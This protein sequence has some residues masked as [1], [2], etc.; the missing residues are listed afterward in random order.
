LQKGEH[1]EEKGIWIMSLALAL[2]FALSFGAAAEEGVTDTSI[3]IGQWGPQTGPA[4]PWGAVARGT[5]VYF[6]MINDEGGINGRKIEYRMFDDAYNPAKTKAGVK[7]LQEGKGYSDGLQASAPPAAWPSKT[8]SW[9]RRSLGRT[10]SRV[11]SLDLAA[12]EISL[13]RVS[14]LLFGG[15]D[16]DQVCGRKDYG[17]KKVAIA[18]QNDDYGKNGVAGAEK[19]LA[20]STG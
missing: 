10:G 4:A 7:E 16:S 6:Q 14:S 13:C 15:P 5:G 12:P 9:K 1:Y 2:L 20:Q 3:R 19:Q 11:S 17:Q 8:I 18:Y